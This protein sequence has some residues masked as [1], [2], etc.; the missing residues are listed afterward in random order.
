MSSTLLLELIVHKPV[1]KRLGRHEPRV[2]KRRPKAYPLLRQPRAEL[3]RQ[4]KMA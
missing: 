4:L 2:R 1:P 3:R